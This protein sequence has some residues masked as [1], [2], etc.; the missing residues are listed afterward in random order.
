MKSFLSV[1]PDIENLRELK[2]ELGLPTNKPI[3]YKS[4]DGNMHSYSSQN[5]AKIEVLERFSDWCILTLTLES[6]RCININNLYLAEMQRDD[7]NVC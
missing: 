2:R 7:F 5:V 6:G 3:V 1:S 4:Y